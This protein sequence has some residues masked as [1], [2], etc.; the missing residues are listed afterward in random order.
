MAEITTRTVRVF[1]VPRTLL[2][3]FLKMTEAG[4]VGLYF[5]FGSSEEAADVC[6]IGQTGNVGNRIRQH[7]VTKDYWE[8]ALVAVSLTN[9]WTDT[10]VGYMEWQAIDKAL[11][12]DRFR[13]INGNGASNRHTPA[14]LEADCNEYLD[15]ISVL[16]TTLGFPAMESIQKKDTGSASELS[17]ATSTHHLSFSRPG[18]DGKGTLTPEG[19]IVAAGSYGRLKESD[20]CPTWIVNLRGK[21]AEK[22]VV[23]CRDDRLILL[24]DHLFNS[25]SAAAAAL[26]GRSINGR[27]SWKNSSG[28]TLDELERLRL[29]TVDVTYAEDLP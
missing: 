8:R 1:D 19:L 21:L 29:D 16:L 20:S 2:T 17:A 6:Y 7:T 5:L 24:K 18:C 11:R 23:E 25:P 26:V 12:A 13:L 4:Q 28:K 22:G 15:T 3:D 10:H 14:P 27:T 9:T